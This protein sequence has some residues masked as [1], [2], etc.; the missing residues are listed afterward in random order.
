MEKIKR[1]SVGGC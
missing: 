1:P